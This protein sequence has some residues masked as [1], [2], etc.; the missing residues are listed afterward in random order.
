M[1]LDIQDELQIIDF[2][3]KGDPKAIAAV[4]NSYFN[5]R[6]IWIS[7]GWD[8][9]TLILLCDALELPPADK[10]GQLFGQILGHLKIAQG[11]TTILYGRIQGEPEPYWHVQLDGR[12][13]SPTHDSSQDLSP[14]DVHTMQEHQKHQQENDNTPHVEFADPAADPAEA[15]SVPSFTAPYPSSSSPEQKKQ[16]RF[17]CCILDPQYKNNNAP[18]DDRVLLPLDSVH[19]ILHIPEASILPVPYMASGVLGIYRYRGQML[20]VVDLW[21]QLTTKP[22]SDRP[23]MSAK[24]NPLITLILKGLNPHEYIGLA[25][26]KLAGNVY[27][28]SVEPTP[29]S[30]AFPGHRLPFI[31]GYDP[32]SNHP[33][34]SI[35][36]LLHD[37]QLQMHRAS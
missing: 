30:S 9:K 7:V 10:M 16:D 3:Q 22:L 12:P 14:P 21:Q 35:A 23:R 24:I 28:C 36:A 18:G 17:L 11:H 2:A 8:D 31:A 6:H 13:S 33:I 20:W 5:E 4:L 27:H 1:S 26:P 15:D 32:I 37:H 34:L 29:D 19:T 25:I